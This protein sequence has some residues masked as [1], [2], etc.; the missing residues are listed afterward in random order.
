MKQTIFLFA[1][2]L[3]LGIQSYAQTGVAINTTGA[4]PDNSAMLDVSST[5][6][7]IL[8]PR[9][10]E[11]QRTAITTP[12]KGL[13]VYQNDGT[14]GFYYF[15]GTAW[16]RLA[17][18]TFTETDPVFGLSAAY[19]IT[20][21]NISNWST[22]YG[23]G[24]HAGLYRPVSY[25]P[26]WSEITSNPFSFTSAANNQLLKYNSTTSK[27]ENWTPN[28]LTSFTETDPDFTVS[29]A[30]GITSAN[31]S[32]WNTSFG[33]GNHAGLYRPVS[34]VPAWSEITSNPFSFSSVTNNQL[35]KYN[36]TT[37]KWENWSPDFLTSYT[38][39]DPVYTSKFDITGAANGDLLKFDGSKFVKYTPNFTES[40]YF[41]NSKT[42]VKLVASNSVTDVDIVFAPKGNGAI[43]VQ[44]PS[45]NNAGGNNRGN[46][47]IDLQMLRTHA[48]EVASGDYSF[49]AGGR[50]N[51]ASGKYSAVVGGGDYDPAF[52]QSWGN[53]AVGDYTFVAGGIH[54][55]A[56]EDYSGIIGGGFNVT[57][58]YGA[59]VGGGWYNRASG[60]GSLVGGGFENYAQSYAEAVFGFF[61]TIG[62]GSTSSAVATDRL[63]V[64]GNGDA[65]TRRNAFT[66]LKNANTTI[67]GNLTINANGTN[68]GFTFPETRGANGQVL[69]TN[70]SGTLSWATPAAGTVT[71]V[72]GTAPINSSGGATPVISISA[73]TTSTAGS[74][75]AADKI[76]L[77]AISGTNTGDQTITLSGDVTGSGTGSIAATISSAS[78]SNSKMANMDANTMKVNN[79]ASS[80]SPSDL[81]ITANT[82]PARS[83][84]GNLVAKP[85]T[86]FALSILDDA[87]A[88][89]VRTTIGAGTGNGTVT[90]VTATSPIV[91]S[92]GADPVISISAATTSAAGSMSAADKTKLNGIDGSETKV[93]AGTNIAI[94]GN[95]TTAS[96]YIVSF[97]SGTAAG[98]MQYWNGTA[99]VSVNPGT[100]G[101]VLEFRNGAPVW[102]DKNVNSLSIGDAYQGGIVAYILQPGD[103]GYV[104]NVMHGIIAAPTD[105]S[106]GTSWGC[107]GTTL[108]G[109]D[110][111]AL[112]TGAQNTLDIL[113][114]CGTAGIAARIC[115]D[116]VLNGYSDWY[117]PSRDE[118]YKL[119]L[120]KN[121]IGGFTTTNYAYYWSSSEYNISYS[122][123]NSWAQDFDL[124]LQYGDT[125]S[126]NRR[127]RAIRAF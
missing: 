28:F 70:G 68:T 123:Y 90:S 111:T 81:S 79:T 98:Q 63:F 69:T 51:K 94:S 39:N 41:F 106:I 17:S 13:L 99:W 34:Y 33:W 83:S 50:N 107:W 78:V 65:G 113:A 18:G 103:P 76:K 52:Q 15:D 6:K 112:G 19:G 114:G 54:N 124:A 126:N 119:Y 86:D 37:S 11:E 62:G 1:A 127:V 4:E 44:Q 45:G 43:M 72:T 57:S 29:A 2:A 7:G 3:L 88:T 16:T 56:N 40:N 25:V 71:A 84:S 32:N 26:A 46:H 101:Q 49:V 42:G 30:H 75:S 53:Y 27:W 9:L 104:S 64:I 12:A 73:A 80:A 109:A 47:A 61:S 14:E 74:M 8:I 55:Y 31:I 108:A 24:N 35:L 66:M 95:G 5:E 20:S 10:T 59:F 48:E 77:N 87:S 125:K 21:T 116:L 67:G 38:E 85:V 110:G 23:W 91:S 60:N 102:L 36:A 96:P 58:G 117:L 97:A 100:W 105:Q 89:A 121:A 115:D 120:N 118:L 122:M 22:A 82:F 93:T 92:G